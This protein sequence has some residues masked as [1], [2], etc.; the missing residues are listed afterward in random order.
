ML[1][2]DNLV[3]KG[4]YARHRGVSAAMVSHWTKAGR[5]VIVDG[6]VD[7]SAS[8]AALA[9]SR[10]PARGG[11][12]G[13]SNGTAVVAP[14]SGSTA[15]E[16]GSYTD[17]RT[18]RESFNAK[19]AELDYLERVGKLVEREAYDRALSDALEPV[20]ACLDRLAPVLGPL[21]TGETDARK[22]QNNIDDAVDGVRRDMESTI[23]ALMAGAARQ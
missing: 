12:G 1:N 3:S 17:V 22:V 10:D 13:K 19:E 16:P 7:V 18:T 14:P 5:I 11:K 23:R 9:A 6:K 8:D 21:V 4:D 15:P 2:G 20:M